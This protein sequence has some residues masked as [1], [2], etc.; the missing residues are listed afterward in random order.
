M[1]P[2]ICVLL[3]TYNGEKYLRRQLDSI[4]AQ[5]NVQV[6]ILAHDDG[7]TDSTVDILN[8]YNIPVI[9]GRHL[10]A[11]H[12]FFYLMEEASGYDYYA[13]CDQDDI[14]DADKLSCAVRAIGK[15][16]GKALDYIRKASDLEES[17]LNQ[18]PVL[19][20]SSTR[21]V[22][23]DESLIQ[24]HV[25]DSSRSLTSRLF[26]SSISGNT[27]VFNRSMRDIAVMHHPEKMVMH[28]SWMVKL[29]IALGGSLI[30]DETPHMDYRMH[31]NNVVGME[32]NLKQ[33][34]DKFRRV[35]NSI[36]EGQ[37]LIDICGLYGVMVRPEYRQMAADAEKSRTD[38]VI[39]KKFMAEYGID[40]KSRGFNL[41]FAMKV[42]KGHL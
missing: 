9:G 40:F 16:Q 39:R 3:C 27:V 2:S 1:T 38:K 33:K 37:E 26:Y 5:K 28:D 7:S 18:K 13:F 4:K 41:A 19:Y 30:I 29:C 34:M 15:E 20:A 24:V 32:L 35:V 6:S 31:G 23:D 11:A 42:K 36:G 25:V 17:V 21:L 14:W 22:N 8:E 10:G 12:G